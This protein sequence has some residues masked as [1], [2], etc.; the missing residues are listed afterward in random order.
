MEN[1][2][3][4]FLNHV[5]SVVGSRRDARVFVIVH[6]EAGMELLFNTSDLV[7]KLGMLDVAKM[8]VMEHQAKFNEEHEEEIRRSGRLAVLAV[9]PGKAN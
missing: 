3:Q 9:E 6:S 2:A 8:T 7:M 5:C 4:E 1:G